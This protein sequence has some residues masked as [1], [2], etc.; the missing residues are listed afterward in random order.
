[1]VGRAG[2]LGQ[3]EPCTKAVVQFLAGDSSHFKDGNLRTSL[4]CSI[5]TEV[6][7]FDE[8]GAVTCESNCELHPYYYFRQQ[9]SL[10]QESR[11]RNMSTRIMDLVHDDSSERTSHGEE[12]CS[13]LALLKCSSLGSSSGPTALFSV[14]LTLAMGGCAVE[15]CES[16]LDVLSA[17]FDRHVARA[18]EYSATVEFVAVNTEFKNDLAVMLSDQ[19]FLSIT[20]EYQGCGSVGTYSGGL[21]LS[22]MVSEGT[23]WLQIPRD[24]CTYTDDEQSRDH[25]RAETGT[26]SWKVRY[27]ANCN[28]S[29]E[30]ILR[31][32]QFVWESEEGHGAYEYSTVHFP[33]TEV[34]VYE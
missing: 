20:D 2:T 18:A 28:A 16:R 22:A 14:V 32:I 12:G 33:L 34:T 5:S 3:P 11:V 15:P 6:V 30:A 31:D 13:N 19:R 8:R 24:V 9:E 1:M 7:R 29:A 25:I 4:P 10:T 17:G 27:D 26:V 21:D 23:V